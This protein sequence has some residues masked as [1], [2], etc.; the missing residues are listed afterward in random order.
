[1][2][3]GAHSAEQYPAP[4]AES[5]FR[6]FGGPIA[7]FVQLCGGYALASR[8]CFIDG[9]R[10]WLPA[11]GLR[12]TWPA[13]IAVMLTA[14]M[15]AL[16]ALILSWRTYRR[17]QSEASGD[18]HHLM[19]VGAGRRRFPRVVGNRARRWIFGYHCSHSGRLCPAAALQWVMIAALN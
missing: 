1:M 18:E 3:T 5:F 10:S 11:A 16:M 15:I 13:M 19:E 6:L 14:I 2:T 9:D 8:P 4:R 17:A 7:W 12:W